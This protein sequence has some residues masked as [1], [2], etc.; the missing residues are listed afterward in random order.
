MI[1]RLARKRARQVVEGKD[2][3]AEIDT[4]TLTSLLGAEKFKSDIARKTMLPGVAAGLAWTEAGGD[5]LY[6]EVSLTQKDEKVTL[7][8]QLGQVMQESAKAARSIV[9]N[10]ADQFRIDR[11]RIEETGVH[12]HVPAGAV[13][14]D[15]PSAGVTMATAL[16][17]AYSNIAVEDGLAMTGEITLRGNVMPVG[18]IKEKVLAAHRAG[19]KMVL[20]PG[21]NEKDLIEIGD[22]LNVDLEFR[23]ASVIEDVLKLALGED[24]LDG[25]PKGHWYAD[26]E[27]KKK[28]KKKKE[29]GEE[30]EKYRGGRGQSR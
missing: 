26:D 17:S 9:W 24:I 22:D 18:G 29:A 23:F 28:K 3:D 4:Q 20:M 19:I 11:E 5:V 27:D 12:L 15:G 16:A 2:S 21:K 1:G 8:G 6:I 25:K 7:T 14:K 30:G 10:V 13:P